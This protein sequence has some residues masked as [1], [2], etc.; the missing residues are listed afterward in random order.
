M[1]TQIPNAVLLTRAGNGHTSFFIPG[2]TRDTITDY[3]ING[4]LPAPGTILPS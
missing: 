3:L 1:A 2:R 4:T